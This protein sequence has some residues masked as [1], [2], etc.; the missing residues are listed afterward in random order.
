MARLDK[1]GRKI[2]RHPWRE[3]ITETLHA[4]DEAWQR[5]R[6]AECIGYETEEREFAERNPRPNLRDI[7]LHAAGERR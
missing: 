1:R 4:A 7:L 5:Q 3:Y 2:G 6:D